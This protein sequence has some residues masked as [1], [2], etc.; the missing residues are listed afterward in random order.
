MA[1]EKLSP[2]QSRLG[3]PTHLTTE[4]NYRKGDGF[5]ID[6]DRGLFY[7]KE[8][9]RRVTLNRESEREYGHERDCQHHQTSGFEPVENGFLS[10]GGA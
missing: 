10:G 3:Y 9:C 4:P 1:A 5:E 7:C 6:A 8:C 2:A